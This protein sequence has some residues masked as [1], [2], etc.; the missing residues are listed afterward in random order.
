MAIV[1]ENT[2]N[3]YLFNGNQRFDFTFKVIT[4]NGLEVKRIR[5]RFYESTL[6][7]GIDY[8]IVVNND[9]SS[10]SN[11]DGGY[12][13]LTDSGVEKFQSG[14]KITIMAAPNINQELKLDDNYIVYKK[15]IE[16][17][18]D[19]LTQLYL[20]LSTKL[21]RLPVAPITDDEALISVKDIFSLADDIKHYKDDIELFKNECITIEND[22]QLEADKILNAYATSEEALDITLL[23]KIMSPKHVKDLI[24]NLGGLEELEMNDF[25][26]NI[27]SRCLRNFKVVMTDSYIH[28]LT[29][30]AAVVLNFCID[31]VIIQL[32]VEIDNNGM[33]FRSALS[34]MPLF[35]NWRV[36]TWT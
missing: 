1:S 30:P 22:I 25:N 26:I 31:S 21:K 9:S 14:D 16:K 34:N 11:S 12:I 10:G 19:K 5:D 6:T 13:L 2:Y 24:V 36:L 33:Y 27:V 32:A 3:C 23:D 18:L 17:A 15:D 7:L 29:S 35:D 28:I 8:S 20:I 4:D